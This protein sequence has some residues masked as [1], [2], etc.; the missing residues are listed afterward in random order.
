MFAHRSEARNKLRS[1][2][3]LGKPSGAGVR[4]D[5]QPM[6]AELFS[7]SQLEQHA[8]QLAGLREIG[9]GRGRV[10]AMSVVE[11]TLGRD[12]AGV[13]AVMDFTTR[14]SYRH[15][16][17]AIG[18]RSRLSEEEI[19]QAAVGL[20]G[21]S[22]PRLQQPVRADRADPRAPGHPLHPPAAVHRRA[23]AMDVSPNGR[24]QYGQRGSFL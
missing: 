13:Y 8:R 21:R 19:A 12:P 20:A 11:R 4:A 2:M 5:E 24:P 18:K 10:E 22:A 3:A 9:P 7:V 16:V 17:E 23:G 1:T 14:D 6:R 15:I